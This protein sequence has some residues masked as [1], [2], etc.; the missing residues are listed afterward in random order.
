MSFARSKGGVVASSITVWVLQVV[1]P[2]LAVCIYVVSVLPK[3]PP[4]DRTPSFSLGVYRLMEKDGNG[5]YGYL[6]LK[7]YDPADAGQSFRDYGRSEDGVDGGLISLDLALFDE[8]FA[9]QDILLRPAGY[10]YEET[11][12]PSF[13]RIT[14]DFYARYGSAWGKSVFLILEGSVG[15]PDFRVVLAGNLVVGE[16]ETDPVYV[17]GQDLDFE[18]IDE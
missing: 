15:D 6:R 3:D 5:Y 9:L 10:H 1:L 14:Y 7:D 18:E 2:L 11:A 12:T 4:L 8:E 13:S 17:G 16:Y